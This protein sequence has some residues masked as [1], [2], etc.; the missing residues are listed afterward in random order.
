GSSAER[1]GESVAI[2]VT[3]GHC[4]A[5]FQAKDADAGKRGRCPGCRGAIEVPLPI[6]A[7]LVAPAASSA[8][9]PLAAIPVQ[10]KVARPAAAV[11]APPAAAAIRVL[12][13]MQS[14]AQSPP[15]VASRAAATPQQILGAFQ[16]QL[17]PMPVPFRYRLGIALVWVVM[18]L[19][20]ACYAG[21]IA[22]VVGLLG[23]HAVYSVRLFGVV[24]GGRSGVVALL[25]YLGPL[26]AGAILVFF[27]VKPFFAKPAKRFKPRSLDRRGDPLLFA[28]VE[29]LCDVVGA[30]YPTRIDVD[31]QV[32]ASASFRRGLWSLF[33]DD[34]V[35][36]LGLPLAAGLDLR[37]FA[38]VLAHEFGHFSQGTAMRFSFLVRSISFWFTRVVYE[39]D[40]WDVQLIVW[41]RQL[42]IRLGLI[43]YLARG[44]IWLTRKALWVLMM[45]GHLVSGFLL[46]QMEFDADRY[47]A[48]LAGSDCFAR[49]ARQLALLDTATR[50]AFADLD[51]FRREGRLADDLPRLIAAN[52]EQLPPNILA[53]IDERLVEHETGLFDTHPCDR[54]RI[55]NA[56][57]LHAPGLFHRQSPATVLFGDF[58][59]LCRTSTFDFYRQ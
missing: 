7:Q 47:E 13:A 44:C 35:L 4:Q 17:E 11:A 49:T 40:A 3:C 21:L 59:A 23:L 50:G 39:R 14:R 54:D 46:R 19:L 58:A 52:A 25:L 51:E 48:R 42:D 9:R 55:A 31:C 22:L 2:V 20:P 15:G 36:T 16:G 53:Q 26:A 45:L 32:N 8:Q 6:A 43:V 37:Q 57:A 24:R 18:I 33:S 29:R 1:G 27:M 34:L 38:G 10:P 41:S 56:R 28:F 5:S 12:P 30:P